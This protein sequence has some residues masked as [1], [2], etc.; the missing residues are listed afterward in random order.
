[1]SPEKDYLQK[2]E[3]AIRQREWSNAQTHLTNCYLAHLKNYQILLGCENSSTDPNSKLALEN[4]TQV[5][6]L[7]RHTSNEIAL[8]N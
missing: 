4:L 5:L 7:V 1:M 3:K 2:A 6:E 8:L